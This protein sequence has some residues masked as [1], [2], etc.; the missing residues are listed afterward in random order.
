MIS[1]LTA[2]G[3]DSEV[4]RCEKH[5]IPVKVGRG[6]GGGGGGRV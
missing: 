1:L 5:I 4:R 2:K 3:P 6:S